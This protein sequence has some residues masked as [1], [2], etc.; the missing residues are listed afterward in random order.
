M[1]LFV[2]ADLSDSDAASVIRA[3]AALRERHPAARWTPPQQLHLTMVFI[4]NRSPAELATLND[5]I[6]SVTHRAVPFEVSM[7]Q[8]DGFTERRRGGGVAWLRVADGFERASALSL[9]LD[10]QMDSR[11]FTKVPPRPHLTLAR[12]VPEEL[13]ADLRKLSGHLELGW[14]VD[15][16]VLFR[17][18]SVAG[19]SYYEELAR[20]RFGAVGTEGAS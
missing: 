12:G 4:G 1:R 3:T 7:G 20:H 5:A 6:S 10:Q 15:N 2:A 11:A 13:L 18:R 8:G 9:E 17:S 16:I 14:T 19:G